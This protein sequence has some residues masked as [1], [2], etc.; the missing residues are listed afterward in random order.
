MSSSRSAIGLSVPFTDGGLTTPFAG[1]GG[2]ADR[3]LIHH[4]QKFAR[5]NPPAGADRTDGPTPPRCRP[6]TLDHE[7]TLTLGAGRGLPSVGIGSRAPMPVRLH[8]FGGQG[9]RLL[10]TGRRLYGCRSFRADAGRTTVP[11]AS[12]NTLGNRVLQSL[13]Q[14]YPR[15]FQSPQ[16][17]RPNR[18]AGAKNEVPQSRVFGT[19]DDR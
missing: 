11:L 1:M 2:E 3:H 18:S 15:H 14:G 9:F 10:T 4:S 5:G 16:L 13:C 7:Q 8:L 17:L 19:R 12:D 6:S